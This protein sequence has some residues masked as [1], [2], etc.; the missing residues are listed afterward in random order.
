MSSFAATRPGGDAAAPAP[1]RVEI[2]RDPEAR[3]WVAVCDAIPLAT[4][5]DSVDALIERVWLIAPEVAT[6]NGL[7][8]PLHL[9][10]VIETH[11]ADG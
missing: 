11:A 10:F 2:F 3:Q 1:L 6:L 9:R 4:E 7:E 8:S 5:A